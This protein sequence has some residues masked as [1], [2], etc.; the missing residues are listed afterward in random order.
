MIN[1]VFSQASGA[2]RQS[3]DRLASTAQHF[4]TSG[5]SAGDEEQ[6]AIPPPEETASGRASQ[7]NSR[8]DPEA[9]PSIEEALT[10]RISEA[11]AIADQLQAGVSL[12]HHVDESV[13]SLLDIIA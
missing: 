6:R 7:P 10:D 9:Q 5:V 3:T 4:A 2:I 11:R 13:G 1:A 8:D 12:I